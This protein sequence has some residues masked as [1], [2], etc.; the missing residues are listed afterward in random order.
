MPSTPLTPPEAS[1][2]QKFVGVVTEVSEM[3]LPPGAM[4]SQVNLTSEHRGLLRSRDGL[5]PVTFDE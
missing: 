4:V 2:A 5:R 1:V 3:A